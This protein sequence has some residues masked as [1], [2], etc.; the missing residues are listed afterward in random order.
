VPRREAFRKKEAKG[1]KKGLLGLSEKKGGIDL[2]DQ[3]RR[4]AEGGSSVEEL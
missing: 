2:G 4:N 3:N 1:E